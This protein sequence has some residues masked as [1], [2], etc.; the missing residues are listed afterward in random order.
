[1]MCFITQSH[2]M[3]DV[4]T[5][6]LAKALLEQKEESKSGL[7][8]GIVILALVLIVGTAVLIWGV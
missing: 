3:S 8:A 1:M 4:S 2:T 6:A 5:D 7:V